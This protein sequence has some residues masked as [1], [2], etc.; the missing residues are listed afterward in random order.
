MF[1]TVKKILSGLLLLYVVYLLLTGLFVFLKDY[2]EPHTT[3]FDPDVTE[4]TGTDWGSDRAAIIEE[5]EAG[6][7]TRINL[8]ENAK[9]SI[10]ITNYSLIPSEASD[11]FYGLILDSANRGVNVQL[12]FNG[13]IHDLYG[14]LNKT[15]L[16][17]VHHPNIEL[18]FYEPLNF[19]K[20][21]TLQNQLH[22]KFWL[23]D[24]TYALSGGRNIGDK[25]FLEDYEGANVHD[26]D[27]LVINTASDLEASG[28]HDFYTYFDALWTHEFT[29][30]ERI[31]EGEYFKQRGEEGEELLLQKLADAKV[32]NTLGF[33]LNINWE[34]HSFPTRKVSLITNPIGRMKSEPLVLKTLNELMLKAENQVIMQ[35]PYLVVNEELQD[36][37]D[38]DEMQAD[39]HVLTN[40]QYSTPNFAAIAGMLKYRDGLLFESDQ[41]YGYQGDGSIHAKSY[42]LDDRLSLIG[43]FNLD[44]RSAFLSTENLVVIDSEPLAEHLTNNIVGLMEQSRIYNQDGT[45]LPDEIMEPKEIPWVK[46]ALIEI[47]RVIF[48]PF[49][50]LL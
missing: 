41:V 38:V 12:L 7:Q 22:D 49:D 4:F 1:N 13:F 33:G 28:L 43:S 19:L 50:E 37:L 42:V 40:S 11:V 16:A 39:V 9:E 34:E 32:E 31:N 5:R 24:D 29:T 25:Y 44:P 23:I 27:V 47:A 26:R 46:K 35:S 3:A 21:W 48:Y 30:E 18:R 8:L 45:I 36:I 14:P 15:Y 10:K 2:E 6:L 20:P 17:L